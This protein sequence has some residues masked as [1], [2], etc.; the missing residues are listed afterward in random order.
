MCSFDCSPQ[1]PDPEGDALVT[2][3]KIGTRTA[4][5]FIFSFFKRAWRSGEDVDVCSDVLQEAGTLLEALPPGSFF[6]AK[7]ISNVWLDSVDKV[8]NFLTSICTK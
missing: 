7:A 1:V 3:A 2:L 8:T 6:N 5:T 4:L